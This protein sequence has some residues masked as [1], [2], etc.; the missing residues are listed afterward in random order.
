MAQKNLTRRSAIAQ[1]RATRHVSVE[2][3]STAA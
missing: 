2:I 1:E 3:L